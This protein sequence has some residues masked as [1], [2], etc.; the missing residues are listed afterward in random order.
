MTHPIY[1][2]V[3]IAIP[4]VACREA[5]L[6]E[7]CAA[8]RRE[9]VGA[10]IVVHTHVDGT[11][12]RVDFP[13]VMQMAR[14]I[15]RPWIMQCE[16]DVILAPDFGARMAEALLHLER[17]A[18][19]AATFFT[20]SGRDLDMLSAGETW[21]PMRAGAFSM[22]QCFAVR[23]ELIE[24]FERWA[25]AWYAAN[26]HHNR[27]ADLLLGAWLRGRR[28]RMLAHVP[29]LVQHRPGPSTLP[30]HYGARQ[31]ESFRR[32]FAGDA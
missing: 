4:T 30:K 26:P 22:S 3:T 25:P 15:G 7:L 13:R 14:A 21:R 9:C 23:A 16:D 31:S 1:R 19:D 29:S 11:P 17:T 8:L 24:G 12:A 2:G 6:S 18:M 20:R 28:A 5:M 27:A 32:A 10:H